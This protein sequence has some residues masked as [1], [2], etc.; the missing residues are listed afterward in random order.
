MTEAATDLADNAGEVNVSSE[1]AEEG[2]WTAAAAGD[3]AAA[4]Q[5]C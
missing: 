5:G 1:I 3:G 4:V 2:R